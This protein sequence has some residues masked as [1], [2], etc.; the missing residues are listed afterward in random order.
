MPQF[1]TKN[2]IEMRAL[3][4]WLW[5]CSEHNLFHSAYEIIYGSE[6]DVGKWPSGRYLFV[7]CI[8]AF[9][10]LLSGVVS[11]NVVTMIVGAIL[12]FAS[13][14]A[15]LTSCVKSESRVK[16]ALEV[17]F[18]L[19]VFGVVVYGYTATRSFVLGA[20]TLFIV[21]MVSVAFMLSY[22]LPK[23]RGKP[24]GYSQDHLKEE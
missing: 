18:M 9:L 7:W 23:I 5:A 6:L 20:I 15:Y 8:L 3:S 14:S 13:T 12:L 2:S 24:R 4:G 16:R 11:R 1:L 17:F 10:T 22:L 21:A 19:L